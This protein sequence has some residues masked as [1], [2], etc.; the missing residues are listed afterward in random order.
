M[1]LKSIATELLKNAEAEEHF[2]RLVAAACSLN[3]QRAQQYFPHAETQRLVY[4]LEP[5]REEAPQLPVSTSSDG[6][7]INLG[8]ALLQLCEPFTAPGSP[9]AAKIDST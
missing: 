9:H 7:M 2:F 5:N 8:A 4:A 3:M 1:A 6:F